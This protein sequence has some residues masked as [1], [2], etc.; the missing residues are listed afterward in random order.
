MD[1]SNYLF[2]DVKP[3]DFVKVNACSFKMI[4]E[5]T[6][7]RVTPK[8]GL[9]ILNNAYDNNNFYHILDKT[10]FNLYGEQT[11]NNLPERYVILSKC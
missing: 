7:K 11:R 10:H 4:F 9:I 3:G 5:T 8:R 6:V 1:D 2:H